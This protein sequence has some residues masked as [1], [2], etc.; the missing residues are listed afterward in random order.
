MSNEEA[1]KWGYDEENRLLCEVD[2]VRTDGTWQGIEIS[3]TEAADRF[4]ALQQENADL[5]KKAALA[6][7]AYKYWSAGQGEWPNGIEWTVDNWLAR[8][9]ALTPAATREEAEG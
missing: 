7:E 1:L 5:R 6:D 4:N 9:A 3:L 8:Y 2:L